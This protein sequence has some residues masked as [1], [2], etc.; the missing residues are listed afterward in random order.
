MDETGDVISLR[1]TG[2]AK[3]AGPGET[4]R[5]RTM[6]LAHTSSA[7]YADLNVI[8]LA[9]EYDVGPNGSATNK[10]WEWK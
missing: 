2:N 7:K 5:F 1:G 3:A 4:A 10:C 6:I 9:G 8:G